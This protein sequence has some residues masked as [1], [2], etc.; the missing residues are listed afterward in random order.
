MNYRLQGVKGCAP[1]IPVPQP[2]PT[3]IVAP[4][5]PKQ[6]LNLFP[7]DEG[8]WKG[9]I[10]RGI[11]KPYKNYVPQAIMPANEKAAMMMEINKN[12]FD[13]I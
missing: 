10:Y 4:V 9:T 5:E 8:F 6:S 13:F 12:F 7:L 2:K 1:K 11:Y 3:P